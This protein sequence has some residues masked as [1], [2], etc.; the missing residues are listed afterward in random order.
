LKCDF[1]LSNALYHH[2]LDYD[3]Y[4]A[5]YVFLLASNGVKLWSL[6]SLC[7]WYYAWMI[8]NL[9]YIV[10][11][12][13]FEWLKHHVNY[14]NPILWIFFLRPFCLFFGQLITSLC[15]LFYFYFNAVLLLKALIFKVKFCG[16]NS[17]EKLVK[18][19]SRYYYFYLS[20]DFVAYH[21][22]QKDLLLFFI[23][24]STNYRRWTNCSKS[25]LKG[26][27]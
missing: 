1:H 4:T 13:I 8:S 26:V 22:Q 5:F 21:R 27:K 9:F 6:R 11:Y 18:I 24:L 25:S 15:L 2:Y 3:S 10:H 16:S 7:T 17:D 14:V 12:N 20:M 23:F 19:Q